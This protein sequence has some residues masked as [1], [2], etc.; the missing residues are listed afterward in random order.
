MKNKIIAVLMLVTIPIWFLPIAF[1]RL[2]YEFGV[3][4]YTE[5]YNW[6]ESL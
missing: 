5:I 6:L 3:I 1:T 4:V 2:L